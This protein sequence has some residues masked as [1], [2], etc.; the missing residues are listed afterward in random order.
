MTRL[1]RSLPARLLLLLTV[2]APAR[3]DGVAFEI[4]EGV[5]DKK[6]WDLPDVQPAE[7]FTEP[8]FALVGVPKKFSNKGHVLDRSNPLVLRASG[9]VTL[10][11]GEYR[12]LLR[13]RNAARLSLDGRV[14]VQTDFLKANS[15]GHEK[16]PDPPSVRE[17]GLVLPPV[18]H[19]DRVTTLTL[20]GGPHEFRLEAFAGGQRL[21][22]E[23]GEL[24]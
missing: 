11:A 3:A 18:A 7:R 14:V 1:Y 17:E 10:P 15:S 5:P 6:G 4:L 24:V 20:D 16:V 13:A 8:A 23:L 19:Q 12:F 9:R 2:A 22:V 21:R